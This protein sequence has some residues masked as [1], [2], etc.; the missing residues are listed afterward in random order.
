M[1]G[2][3]PDSTRVFDLA[4]HSRT[5]LPDVLTMP[6]MFSKAG[7]YSEMKALLANIHPAPVEGG[8]AGGKKRK[9]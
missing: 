9:Q 5:G 8:K 2:L 4:Y 1:T 6:Q 7:Y 3:R